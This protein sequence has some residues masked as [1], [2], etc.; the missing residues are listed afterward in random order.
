MNHV[1]KVYFDRTTDSKDLKMAIASDDKVR[2]ARELSV[3]QKHQLRIAKQTL[4][5]PDAA[6]GIAGGPSKQEAREI[7]KRLTGKDATEDGAFTELEHKLEAKGESKHEA[8]AVA[9]KVG[10][11][12][13]GKKG[14]EEKSEA[15]RK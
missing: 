10:A 13:Y 5:M 12:K 6:V 7:I 15:G 3:P 11:E 1:N 2:D 4:N 8:S 14:M 9:Y